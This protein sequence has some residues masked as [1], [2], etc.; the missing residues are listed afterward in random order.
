MTYTTYRVFVSKQTGN[1]LFLALYAFQHPSIIGMGSEDGYEKNVV[2]S[3]F[4]F[5]L[6]AALFGHL[7]HHVKQRRRIWLIGSSLV[8]TAMVYGA[9][10][11]RYW[12]SNAREDGGALGV[13]TLLA[14]ASGGQ[15]A[16]ALHAGLPELNTTMVTGALIQLATDRRLFALKNVARNRR[17]L[18]Y[19]SLLI[20][21]F[22]GASVDATLGSDGPALALLLCAITKTL[23]LISF[24]FNDGVM[25]NKTQDEEGGAGTHTP[26][27]KILWGD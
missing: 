10:A 21:C 25:S 14:F 24:L 3:F 22:I 17:V 26:F 18:F 1:T 16:L 23:V 12:G 2:V 15:I 9:A 20:G 5:C 6:G 19:L 13:I 8:Q 4:V 7:G 27:S 11:L